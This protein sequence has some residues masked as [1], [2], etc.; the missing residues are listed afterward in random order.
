MGGGEKGKKKIHLVNRENTFVS[1]DE[2]GLGIRCQRLMN[3]AYL[4]KLGWKLAQENPSLARDCIYSKYLHNGNV[5]KFKN[6]SV[7]WKI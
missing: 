7:V 1:K 2:G 5:T 4:A 3:V 6:G